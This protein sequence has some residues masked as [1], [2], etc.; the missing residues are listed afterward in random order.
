MCVCVCACVCVLYPVT[1]QRWT[2]LCVRVCVCACAR[3]RA[4]VCVLP[5][6]VPE[7]HEV[8]DELGLPPLDEG[9]RRHHRPPLLDGPHALQRRAYII[10]YNAVIYFTVLYSLYIY[11]YIYI[12]IYGYT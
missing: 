11:I 12:Y 5:R 8:G 3:A 10:E 4:R 2:R 6:D 7:V 9:R 1:F